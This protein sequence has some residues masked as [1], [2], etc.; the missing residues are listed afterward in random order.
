MGIDD[1]IEMLLK[2]RMGIRHFVEV[3]ENVVKMN[4]V[5]KFR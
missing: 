4:D 2:H 3:V 5:H 1:A